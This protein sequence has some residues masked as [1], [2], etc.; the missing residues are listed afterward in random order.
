MIDFLVQFCKFSFITAPLHGFFVSFITKKFKK[1]DIGYGFSVTISLCAYAFAIIS[2]YA[3]TLI[4]TA[5]KSAVWSIKT[6]KEL[7]P[8]LQ[9]I[10]VIIFYVVFILS[11]AKL[12]SFFTASKDKKIFI[13]LNDL[14][15]SLA[16]A[17]PY[18]LVP[19]FYLL[20]I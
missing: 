13:H 3:C 12:I 2:Y 4:L 15:T 5:D 7:T 6:S 18:M 11:T 20:F 8:E 17:A 16:S 1:A 14:T 9:T 19:F 10:S